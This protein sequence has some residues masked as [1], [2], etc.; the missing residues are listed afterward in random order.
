MDRRKGLRIFVVIFL[1]CVTAGALVQNWQL[2]ER[3]IKLEPRV[4]RVENT[5]RIPPK[6][7]TINHTIDRTRTIRRTVIE[8]HTTRPVIEI[9]NKPVPGP[10]GPR[11]PRGVPGPRG[12]Q[13][14]QGIEGVAGR[15]DTQVQ[16]LVQTLQTQVNILEGRLNRLLCSLLRCVS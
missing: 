4:T 16:S 13:G 1:I 6:S 15:V 11:G 12:V 7:T 14:I 5:I 3:I 2:R 10:R 9:R 8:R